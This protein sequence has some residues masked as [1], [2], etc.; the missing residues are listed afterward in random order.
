LIDFNSSGN[1]K[2]STPVKDVM[3]EL[4]NE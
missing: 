2:S 3:E 4:G 1:A